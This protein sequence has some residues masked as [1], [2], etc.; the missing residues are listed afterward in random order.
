MTYR[1]MWSLTPP[2]AQMVAMPAHRVDPVKSMVRP[3]QTN[4]QTVPKLVVSAIV[5]PGWSDIR[6]AT[7]MT[8]VSDVPPRTQDMYSPTR[9]SPPTPACRLAVAVIGGGE[10]RHGQRLRAA[11]DGRAHAGAL[12]VGFGRQTHG[13][14][15]TRV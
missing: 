2:P 11:S 10:V 5:C 8:A 4:A 15:Q 1:H 7:C 9:V 3:E 13:R 6:M 14:G 12:G